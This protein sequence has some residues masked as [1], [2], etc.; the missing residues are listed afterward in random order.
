[1]RSED[2]ESSPQGQQTEDQAR[3]CQS[4]KLT[5]HKAQFCSLVCNRLIR[6][7][8]GAFEQFR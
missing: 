5:V 6:V 2:H 3:K 1:M 4:G 8:Q 7:A